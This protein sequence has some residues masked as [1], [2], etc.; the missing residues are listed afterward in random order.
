DEAIHLL[1]RGIVANPDYWR[2][3]EDLGFIYYWDLKDYAHAA[4]AFRLGSERPGALPWMRALAA[5]VAARGGAIQTS[6]LLWSEIARTGDTE[7][8]RQR[9]CRDP[10]SL[11]DLIARGYLRDIPLDPSGEPFT[12]GPNGRAS[13]GPKSKVDL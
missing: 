11:R 1:Q 8:I 4:E 5:S 13:L 9:E 10:L 6:R 7:S 3:W 2:L 12:L